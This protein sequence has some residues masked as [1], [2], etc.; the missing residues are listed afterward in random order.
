MNRDN[1]IINYLLTLARDVAP[2][3][4]SRHAAAI[5]HRNDIISVGVNRMKTHPFQA[6]YGRNSDSIYLHAE[7]AA[8]RHA[9]VALNVDFLER[10]HLYV[11][12]IKQEQSGNFIASMSKPCDGCLRCAIDFGLKSVIFSSNSNDIDTVKL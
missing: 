8:I 5:V 4:K 9:L 6:K 3:R 1:R 10:C 12:R 7:I 2:I 11:V